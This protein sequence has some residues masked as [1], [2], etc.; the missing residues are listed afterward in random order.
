MGGLT[1]EN[2]FQIRCYIPCPARAALHA[3]PIIRY[4]AVPF[5]R[6]GSFACAIHMYTPVG[7]KAPCSPWEPQGA[8][9]AWWC[10]ACARVCLPVV[11]RISPCLAGYVA[12]M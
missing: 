1:A 2:V 7:G 12:G 8:V 5:G 9:P 6:P 3:Q 10:G 4:S 11:R